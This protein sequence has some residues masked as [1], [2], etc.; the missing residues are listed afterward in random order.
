MRA[1]LTPN[2][3]AAVLEST[4]P[5][6]A[7][8][9]EVYSCHSCLTVFVSALVG[10]SMSHG[11]AGGSVAFMVGKVKRTRYLLASSFNEPAW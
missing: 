5:F 11:W 6:S 10:T 2:N 9:L 8:Q 4:R 3:F 1:R 7:S